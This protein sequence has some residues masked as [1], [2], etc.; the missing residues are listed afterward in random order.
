MQK[1]R[2]II[3][4]SGLI[5]LGGL[6]ASH[7]IA[8]EEG[9]PK[10]MVKPAFQH[11]QGLTCVAFSPDGSMAAS[12]CPNN[13]PNVYV[14]DLKTGQSIKIEVW[15]I[16][17]GKKSHETKIPYQGQHYFCEAAFSPDGERIAFGGLED[18]KIRV[19][20]LEGGEMAEWEGH[21]APVVL[22]A[23]APDGTKL[24]TATRGDF[25]GGDGT[26]RIWDTKTG[27]EVHC[28]KEFDD[29]ILSIRF[30][31]KGKE[32]IT[33]CYNGKVHLWDGKTY[34]KKKSFSIKSPL[35]MQKVKDGMV[36]GT[37]PEE[38][39]KKMERQSHFFRY[40]Y[41]MHISPNGEFILVPAEKTFEIWDIRRKRCVRKFGDGNGERL[42]ISPDGK[43]CL[44]G[45]GDW[46][47]K[48][49]LTLWDLER[50]KEIV[51]SKEK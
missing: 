38:M 44:S 41:K 10:K 20:T 34:R 43:L 11:K 19:W 4:F 13:P 33:A 42:G 39:R 8:G 21:G 40:K 46:N 17:T 47:N 23:Y 1:R 28:L 15:D 31:P 5:F 26:V 27:E 2:M 6:M 49:V 9:P 32:L 30:T 37:N 25:N 12:G 29:W 16:K 24:A 7:C 48:V 50:G 3:L 45:E 18:N 36:M 14:W 51:N 35:K 22:F